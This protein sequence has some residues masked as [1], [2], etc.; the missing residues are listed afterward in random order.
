MTKAELHRLVDELESMLTQRANARARLVALEREKR[1]KLAAHD[2]ACKQVLQAVTEEIYAVDGNRS[3]SEQKAKADERYLS[4]VA[5][6]DAEERALQLRLDERQVE[7]DEL[8]IAVEVARLTIAIELRSEEATL[9][10]AR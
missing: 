8:S 6:R 2:L 10:V 7:V 9:A 5:A 1:E 3:R 4:A